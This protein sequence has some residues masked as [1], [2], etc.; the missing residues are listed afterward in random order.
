M[1]FYRPQ[2][3]SGRYCFALRLFFLMFAAALSLEWLDGSQPNFHTRWRGGLARTLLKMGV[4][5]LT[6]SQPSLRTSFQTIMTV[7]VVLV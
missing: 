4:I 3:I 6:V 1:S 5:S 2:K 7:H